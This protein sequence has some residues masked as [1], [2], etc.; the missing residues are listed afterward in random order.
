VFLLVLSLIAQTPSW[1][2]G[3]PVF[4]A[5]KSKAGVEGQGTWGAGRNRNP[6]PQPLA[7]SPPSARPPHLGEE[8]TMWLQNMSV[9]PPEQ[10]QG[11]VTCR[12]TGD[13]VYVMVEDSAWNAGLLDSAGVARIIDRFD[14]TS[15]RDSLHGIWYHNTTVFG[16]PPD[17]IDHDSLIYLI[18]HN[19]GEFMG[20]SFDGF[21]QYFDEYYDSTSMRLWGYHSN[22][23]ECVYLDLYPNNPSQDN[24]IAIAAHEFE[25]MIHWNY[26]Q[27]ESL[28]VN[29]GC[30]EL[31]MWLY[32]SPDAISGF[33]GTPDN[34]L[35]K[36]NGDWADYIKTYLWT[37]FLYEQFGERGGNNLIH[38]IVASPFV[39]IA[40]V[41]SAFAATGLSARFEEVMD[42]WVLAN[43]I[44]DTS[45]L[46]GKY[47][48]FGVRV[49]RF[50]NAG[51]HTTYP[52]SRSNS[53]D[54]WAGE[55]ILFQKGRDLEMGFDGDDA[56][57]FH[58]FM[59]AKDTAG[60]RLI[61]DTLDLDSLQTGSIS[62]PGSD[63]GYQSVWL[64]P[65]SHYPSGRMTYSYTAAATGIAEG[66]LQPQAS[67]HQEAGPTLVCAGA[68]LRLP[69]GAVLHGI[70]G[71]KVD[72]NAPLSAGIY[73]A[74]SDGNPPLKIVVVP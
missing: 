74:A 13:H 9:M 4:E 40:G 52:V 42:Q 45:Y 73:W 19:V 14:H 47:G 21:W 59:V 16:E 69:A 27:A 64:V 12:G 60:H 17:E 51:V 54:R 58:L 61:I 6:S 43:V 28:W 10:Y 20:Y 22:E 53:L 50:N 23:I 55:Y 29:E 5:M 7:L 18:Y 72:R 41:D 44:N 63:T 65:A 71:R 25:H 35:T 57:N 32:G 2:C 48:Y 66:S 56:A 8:R 68:R 49:P 39:S 70:D 62:V 36:W 26:D 34:D 46:G 15:P 3:T 33:N 67:S 1:R 31:A 24:R 37:L 30:A 11:S 38:N